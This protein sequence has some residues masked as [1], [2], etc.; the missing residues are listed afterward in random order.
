MPI[1]VAC[2]S[3]D[4]TMTAPDAAAGNVVDCAKCKAPM[5]LPAA[6]AGVEVVVKTEPMM[7]RRATRRRM[8]DD[9]D[10]PRQRDDIDRPQ[11]KKNVLLIGLLIGGGVCAVALLLMA[12]LWLGGII[13]NRSDSPEAVGGG[14]AVNPVPGWLV[15]DDPD[16]KC[17]VP[18]VIAP[19]NADL[20]EDQMQANRAVA[21]RE[22]Y[23][24]VDQF[25][26]GYGSAGKIEEHMIILVRNRSVTA[27]EP[28][29]ETYREI[30]RKAGGYGLGKF[31]QVVGPIKVSGVPG[32]E[33]RVTPGPAGVTDWRQ[34][35][36][37]T[38]GK[39]AFMLA[40]IRQDKQ[41]DPERVKKFF[42]NFEIKP[43]ND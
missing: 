28:G 11:R 37:A 41:P 43:T 15:H 20:T 1:R 6:K 14:S 26:A 25:F 12:C 3:C 10:R 7:A 2:P 40:V 16:Y 19:P 27:Y 31:A 23:A 38:D 36:I 35:R 8:E 13:G 42:D 4:S 17:L 18:D 30:L 39:R 22:G 29:E 9:D 24:R 5:Q 33:F 21:A 34:I 32:M